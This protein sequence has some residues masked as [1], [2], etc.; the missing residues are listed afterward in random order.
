[1]KLHSSFI[2]NTWATNL[3]DIQ[4]LSKFNK[5]IQFWLCDIDIYS[6]H[7]CAIPLKHEKRYHNYH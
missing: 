6:K 3:A 2:D 1:M 4:S 5:G 7:V